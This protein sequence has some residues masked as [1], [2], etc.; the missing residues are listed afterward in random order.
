ML[1]DPMCEVRPFEVM[2][3]TSGV[4][5]RVLVLSPMVGLKVHFIQSSRICA[6]SSCP[7]CAVG[8]AGKFQGYLCVL[9][10]SSR[11]LLRLTS[12]SAR[13]GADAGLFVAGTVLQ[14]SKPREKRPLVLECETTLKAF[15]REAILSRVE[16]LSV[17]ARLHGLPGCVPGMSFDEAAETVQS[18][19]VECMRLALAAAKR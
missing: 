10:E 11:W 12:N 7:A 8:L 15:D 17:V 19:A 16:L 4:T 9:W 3:L 6:G 5:K 18:C 13:R 14:V 1:V 2:K